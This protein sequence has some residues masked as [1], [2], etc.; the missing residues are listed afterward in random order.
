[1][2]V[3]GSGSI[4]HL[5][6]LAIEAKASG[7]IHR[8]AVRWRG[9]SSGRTPRGHIDAVA[10]SPVRRCRQVQ[11]SKLRML[12]GGRPTSAC[13]GSIRCRPCGER[14]I[15]IRLPPGGPRR[16]EGDRRRRLSACWVMSPARQ[17]KSPSSGG[18]GSVERGA[19]ICRCRRLPRHDEARQRPPIAALVQQLGLKAMI[20]LTPA[21][22]R[23]RDI[24]RN[25]DAVAGRRASP[26]RAPDRPVP[27]AGGRA[28]RRAGGCGRVR[29]PWGEAW[30]GFQRPASGEL[31]RCWGGWPVPVGRRV[32]AMDP[33]GHPTQPSPTL[34]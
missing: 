18:D 10:V 12:G 33:M 11:A 19:W 20:R 29:C 28:G 1:M 8:R 9:A 22:S 16:P 7:E 34:L 14:G 2:G 17:W 13:A 21:I 15:D 23:R 26:D 4:W 25:R 24:A 3:P 5:H 30:R 31:G 6:T 32:R 27:S